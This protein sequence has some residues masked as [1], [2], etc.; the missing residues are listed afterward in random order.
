[1][2]EVRRRGTFLAGDRLRPTSDGTTVRAAEGEVL[3]SDGPFVETK[4]QIGGFTLIDC[5]DLDVAI[6]LAGAHP[7]A[8][9]GRVEVGPI[10]P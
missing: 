3:V 8:A 5:P 2:A 1:V 7:L 6:E 10:W 9:L 4:E